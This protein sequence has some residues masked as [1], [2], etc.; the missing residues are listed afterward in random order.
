MELRWVSAGG[1]GWALA[2][3]S[4]GRPQQ[5]RRASR[6]CWQRQCWPR[7]GT[8]AGC[9]HEDGACWFSGSGLDPLRGFQP[10]QGGCPRVAVAL[11]GPLQKVRVDVEFQLA[12]PERLGAPPHCLCDCRASR[13]RDLRGTISG[14]ESALAPVF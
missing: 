5:G 7:F 11:L 1:R 10:L 14:A 2:S 13:V 6:G 3:V 8:W 9:D 12:P 4:A